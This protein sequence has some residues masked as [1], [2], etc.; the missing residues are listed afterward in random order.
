MTHIFPSMTITQVQQ[1]WAN[2]IHK[3]SEIKI[4]KDVLLWLVAVQAQ[5]SKGSELALSGQPPKSQRREKPVLSQTQMHK[6]EH[7]SVS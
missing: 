4:A 2:S 1:L 6:Q 5:S 3:Y 7:L